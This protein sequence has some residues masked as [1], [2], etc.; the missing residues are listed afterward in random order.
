MANSLKWK[1]PF[2][3]INQYIKSLQADY[4][5]TVHE[6]LN[7]ALGLQQILA[8][9]DTECH[10]LMGTVG[11]TGPRRRWSGVKTS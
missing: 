4:G 10:L 9:D 6:V 11:M 2:P 7:K 5:K 8:W 3:S 1:V